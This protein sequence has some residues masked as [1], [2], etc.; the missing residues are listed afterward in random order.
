MPPPASDGAAP[1][2][3]AG[4]TLIDAIDPRLRSD[5]Y[6]PQ[7]AAHLAQATRTTPD[8]RQIITTAARQGPLPDEL[9]AAAL[10]WRIAGALSPTATLATTHSRLRPAWITDVD[11]V[12]GS[13]LAETITSDPAWP[14][15]VAA[16][17][18]ADPHKWTPRDLLS[19]AAEHLAD[20]SADSDP[21]PPGDYARLITY[22]VDAFTHRLQA[23]LGVDFDDIPTPED[24][25]APP[26]PAEEHLLPPDPE[27]TYPTI[28]ERAALDDYFDGAPPDPHTFEYPPDEFDG[29]QFEDLSA[30]RPTPELGITME[31]LTTLRDEYRTV[32]KE[33]TTLD[34]DIRAGNGPAMRAAAEELLRMRHQV[35]ADRPYGHAVTAVMEQWADADADYNDI[36]RMI[37]H[38][39]TQLDALHAAPERRRP[40]HR[41]GPSRSGLPHPPPARA[42]TLTAVSAG[43]R[44]GARRAHRGR[45]RPQDRHRARHRH[46]A[47]RRRTRGPGRPRRTARPP[48]GAAPRARSRRPRRGRRIRR[49]P[50][51]DLRHP[52]NTAGFGTIRGGASARRRPHRLRPH[53]AG[54][55]RRRTGCPRTR[56][57]PT[58]SNPWRRSPIGSALVR[59]DSSDPDTAAALYTLRSHRQR[60]RP[61]SAVALGQR[62]TPPPQRAYR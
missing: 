61:K 4:T 46:R 16:I 50:D 27:D 31:K 57:S 20:A 33:I 51:R 34:A 1:T 42:A 43:P 8:L 29:L 37:E 62:Q 21:I 49:R 25:D 54:H 13:V 35:D 6:W 12:F 3:P 52:R 56:P 2:P 59:A 28:D 45:R 32:C 48:P 9:P 58:G 14:G 60:R 22:T 30:N 38:A 44:R 7:L 5:A 19:V 36:L 39:R 17:S 18:A 53:A 55:P 41:L 23:H 26:D 10:W 11:A 47:R 24:T 40:R 15:L